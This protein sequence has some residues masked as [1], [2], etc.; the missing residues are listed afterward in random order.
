MAERI[1]GELVGAGV[2][3]IAGVGAIDT[4]GESDVTFITDSKHI[5]KLKNCGA[6]AVIVGERVEGLAAPQLISP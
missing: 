6:G 2:G 1:G 4:A 5:A 3:E